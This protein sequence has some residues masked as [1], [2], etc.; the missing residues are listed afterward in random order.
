MEIQPKKLLARLLEAAAVFALAMFLIRLGVCY[1][2]QVWW[3][4][5]ILAGIT[6]AVVVGWRLLKHQQNGD[7]GQW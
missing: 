7:G 6:I 5:L 1:L 3:V 2:S 4:L